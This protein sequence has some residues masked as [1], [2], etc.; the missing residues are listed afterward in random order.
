MSEWSDYTR[1]HRFPAI[2]V[3]LSDGTCTVFRTGTITYNGCKSLSQLESLHCEASRLLTPL[4][5]TFPAI[6]NVVVKFT[7]NQKVNL[8]KIAKTANI[9][10]E[11]DMST[12]LE[13]V[14]NDSVR[15]LVQMIALVMGL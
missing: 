4:P 3:K 15:A 9:L 1:S 8:P 6:V 12:A 7:S 14:L 5:V 11:P 2:F 13:L 10:Y